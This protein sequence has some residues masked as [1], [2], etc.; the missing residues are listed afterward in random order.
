MSAMKFRMMYVLWFLLMVSPLAFAEGNWQQVTVIGLLIAI[1]LLAIMY[2]IGYGFSVNEMKIM[3]TDELYQ[4]IVTIIILGAFTG[5][6]S[7]VNQLAAGFA[8][9][10]G[11]EGVV[12]IQ[13]AALFNVNDNLAKLNSI[14]VIVR[15]FSVEAS[16]EASKTASCSLMA[17]SFNVAGC[18]GFRP[19][20]APISAV[21]TPLSIGAA[22]LQAMQVL[23]NFG[24]GYAITFLLPLGIF[25]RSFKITRGAG[26]LFIALAIAFYLLLP[27]GIV[28]MNQ[29][30]K[31]FEEAGGNDKYRFS[32]DHSLPGFS[33]TLGFGNDCDAFD[34]DDNEGTAISAFSSVFD[35]LDFFVYF[36]LIKITMS[37]V[38]ALLIMVTGLRYMASTFG[39]DID[40][41]ALA[42]I[43]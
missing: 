33:S 31:S 9:E 23:L 42:K 8:T 20:T 10:A 30:M 29:I 28:F 13:D 15:D 43:A 41:T 36:V 34:I 40:V 3:A 18:G 24:K 4:V 38:I 26:G 5:A 27:I 2:A 16:R 32:N 14:E 12:S 17:V 35:Q 11:V 22:E 21:M 25:L 39:V 37:A 19:L 7:V 1:G 6:A